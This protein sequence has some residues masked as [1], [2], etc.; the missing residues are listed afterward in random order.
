MPRRRLHRLGQIMHE[1]SRCQR[2]QEYHLTPQALQM[3][4]FEDIL[5]PILPPKYQIADYAPMPIGRA[6]FNAAMPSRAAKF[7][8]RRKFAQVAERRRC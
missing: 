4:V 6:R 5:L 1:R 3:K 8:F 7:I 2:L